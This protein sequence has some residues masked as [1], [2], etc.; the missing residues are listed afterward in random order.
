[1]ESHRNMTSEARHGKWLLSMKSGVQ[2]TTSTIGMYVARR[3][4]DEKCFAENLVQTPELIIH[5]GM[6]YR[7]REFDCV[8]YDHPD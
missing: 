1:M 4:W 7:L 5:G 8:Y 3:L 6:D 2:R